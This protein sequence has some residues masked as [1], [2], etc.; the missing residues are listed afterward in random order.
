MLSNHPPYAHFAGLTYY[1]G[2]YFRA[3]LVSTGLLSDNMT[4]SFFNL[5]MA[6]SIYYIAVM[7]STC[8]SVL[9]QPMRRSA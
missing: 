6:R 4:I 2:A 9:G 8:E 3:A 5:T 7:L 1:R